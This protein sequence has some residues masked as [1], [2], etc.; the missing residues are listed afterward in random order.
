MKKDNI[1]TLAAI[2]VMALSATQV[3]AQTETPSAQQH[4]GLAPLR[5]A[6]D[7][8]SNNIKTVRTLKA[9]TARA[10]EAPSLF[11]GRTF[12][13]SLINSTDWATA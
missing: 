7:S 6:D 11:Y 8:K 12:Y 5:L 3:V 9:R 13:G 1:K 2:A 4:R 10:S